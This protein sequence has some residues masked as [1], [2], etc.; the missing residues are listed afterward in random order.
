MPSQRRGE[1]QAE[2]GG[3]GGGPPGR[4]PHQDQHAQ[5]RLG[6]DESPGDGAPRPGRDPVLADGR[7]QRPRMAQLRRG[8]PQQHPREDDP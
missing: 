3:A 7:E 2:H 4:W 1:H 6:D 5:G 8:R